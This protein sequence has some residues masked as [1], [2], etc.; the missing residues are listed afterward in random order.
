M[1]EW[2]LGRCSSELFLNRGKAFEKSSPCGCTFVELEASSQSGCR[3][4]AC[5]G[6]SILETQDPDPAALEHVMNSGVID[7]IGWNLAGRAR[8]EFIKPAD[9]GEVRVEGFGL[10]IVGQFEFR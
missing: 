7:P 3:R 2:E 9:T 6:G 5:A 4:N 1:Y 10:R 8:F